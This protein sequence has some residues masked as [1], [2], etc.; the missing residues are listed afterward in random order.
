MLTALSQV[1]TY[2]FPDHYWKV[3]AVITLF[4][5]FVLDHHVVQLWMQT[6]IAR[7][8]RLNGS[9]WAWRSWVID[10]TLL[11]VVQTIDCKRTRAL[12][13][14]LWRA[15]Y[16]L[17]IT[18]ES[19]AGLRNILCSFALQ[20]M[21]PATLW[22][23]FWFL[24][25]KCTV[26][27]HTWFRAL[28][29][30]MNPN[31]PE[32]KY[33]P[34]KSQD[35][36]RVILLFPR[37]GFGK[38]CCRLI[39]GPN[40]RTMFYEAISYNWGTMEATEEILVDGCGKKV[41]RS[42]YEILNT[43]SSLFLPKLLWIDALCIDQES[44]AEKSQQVPLMERIYRNAVITTVFLGRSPLDKHQELHSSA[45]STM[46]YRYDGLV[47]AHDEKTRTHFQDAQLTFDLLKEFRVLAGN[48]LRGSDLAVYQMFESL[49]LSTYKRRQWSAL[50]KMLQHPW[51]ERVWVIQEVALS[52]KVQLR[53]GDETID[54]ETL[55]DGIKKLNDARRFRLWLEVE[56]GV[57]LSHIQNSSLYNIVRINEFRDKYRPRGWDDYGSIIWETFGLSKVLAQSSYFKATNPRDLVF[58]LMS[59]CAKPL[60][61]NY[62]LSVEDVYLDAAKRLLDD[63]AF[64]L[65]PSCQWCR[66][67]MREQL[68]EFGSP[69]LGS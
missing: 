45:T 29:P 53:Y 10:N 43:Y 38:V 30:F 49:K 2:L 22:I 9:P 46:P 11:F 55:C 67:P 48:A 64:R 54:W 32:H 44:G 24:Y 35:D 63:K 47:N 25:A 69:V 26:F 40:M 57:Q 28:G 23:E 36:I 41:T 14:L 59:L 58:G 18:L 21:F 68:H 13:P 31:P 61:V 1:A 52:S 60:T 19:G 37:L 12:E 3:A 51:F 56:H 6:Q 27:F 4:S 65:L 16:R 42:V 7:L 17:S 15:A 66:Q 5:W 62:A 50:L 34:L 8:I 39:Q 33:V 20:R